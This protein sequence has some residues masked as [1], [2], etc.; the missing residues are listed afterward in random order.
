MFG[1]DSF[2]KAPRK[3]VAGVCALVVVIGGA[4]AAVAASGVG[5]PQEES[6][7]AIAAAAEDLGVSADDLT[8]ALE[9]ALAARVDAAV[10]AGR[11]TE[12]QAAELKERIAAGEVPLVGVG[13]PG[14]RGGHGFVHFGGLEAAADYLG[15]SDEELREE[16]F[17]GSSLAD[18]AEEQGVS[19][20]GLVDAIVTA[21][22]EDLGDA[23]AAGRLT[24]AQRD[25]I[26]ATLE[27]RVTEMV[28]RTGPGH[29][30]RGAGM[31]PPLD[32]PNA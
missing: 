10:E 17:A 8:E 24:D 7:A 26:V 4:G 31:V 12:A 13:G 11:L 22:T 19:I 27:A 9:T 5:S 20:D 29:P 6:E 1:R 3:V 28:N 30:D 16:L 14:P 2:T 15:L 25:E 18:V 23:V 32:G 21:A